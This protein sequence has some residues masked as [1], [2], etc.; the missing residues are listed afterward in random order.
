MKKKKKMA[1]FFYYSNTDLL[2]DR[3]CDDRQHVIKS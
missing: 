2:A 3:L 1:R